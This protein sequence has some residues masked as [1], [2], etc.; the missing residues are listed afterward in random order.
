MRIGRMKDF[1]IHI[2]MA[3][4]SFLIRINRGRIGTRLGKQTILL[5]KSG[6]PRRIKIAYFYHEG[7][8]LIVESHGG[9]VTG[10][11]SKKTSYLVL[12]EAR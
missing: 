2:V 5:R 4:N 12:G 1:F 3:I 7:K 8:Y 11:I 9:K 10:R 6:Q